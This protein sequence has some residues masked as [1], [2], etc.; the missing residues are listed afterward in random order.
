LRPKIHTTMAPGL[1]LIAAVAV[2]DTILSFGKADVRIKWPNDVLL[3]GLKTAGILTEL[4]AEIDKVN[5]VIVGVGINV[6]QKKTDFPE[7]LQEIATSIRIGLNCKIRRVAFL[8]RFLRNL[9][10]EYG[11]FK[12]SGLTKSRKKIRHYSSLIN[13]DI[14]LKSG[15]KVISGNVLDIDKNGRLVVETGSGVVVLN[16]GEV[17]TR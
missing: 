2:A 1:S 9:E 10:K 13:T 14:K 3:S 17:T 7:D 12:K 4:S 8:Q 11:L 16:A 6:N 15:R 5:F